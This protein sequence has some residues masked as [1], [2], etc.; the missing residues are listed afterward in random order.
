MTQDP[1]TAGSLDPTDITIPY[2]RPIPELSDESAVTVLTPTVLLAVGMEVVASDGV[3]LGEVTALGSRHFRIT[4]ET[5]QEFWMA[6]DL[7]ERLEGSHVCLSVSSEKA[8]ESS[9]EEEPPE[10]VPTTVAASG[11]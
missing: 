3:A 11:G 5:G 10:A 7:V 4:S 9:L 8:R 6:V 1:E 2:V